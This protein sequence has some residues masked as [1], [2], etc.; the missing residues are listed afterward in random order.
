MSRVYCALFAPSTLLTMEHHVP[1]TFPISRSGR[2]GLIITLLSCAALTAY[3]AGARA[4]AARLTRPLPPKQLSLAERVAYQRS[5][6]EVY[7]HHRIWP[8][9]NPDPKPSLDQVMPTTLIRK[10]VERY[11]RDS[12]ELETHWQEPITSEQLQGEM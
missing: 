4:G 2:S 9:A 1:L 11:L 12:A 7:W 5:I 8:S 3:L 6:E 10:K